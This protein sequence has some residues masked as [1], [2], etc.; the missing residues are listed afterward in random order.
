EEINRIVTDALAT[1]WFASEPDAVENLT[2]EGHSRERIHLVGNVMIDALRQFLPVAQQ[3]KIGHE[4]GLVEGDRIRPFA[5]LTLHRPANV[6]SPETLSK[7][8]PAVEAIADQIPIIFPV[9]PRT[10]QKLAAFTN[11]NSPFSQVRYVPPLR[12]LDF[13]FLLSQARL[14]LS[15]FGGIQ[16]G[17][18]APDIPCLTLR[19]NTE[20][21]ITVTEGTNQLVGNDPA[22]IIAAARGVLAGKHKSGRLPQFWDGRAAERIVQ[23]LLR[24]IRHANGRL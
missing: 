21:P 23:I 11:T 17:K 1:Y 5:L 10:Q 15:D 12:Y 3:S 24:E 19:E 4:L 9:H 14:V 7:V 22:N 6:D 13:L 16:G 18:T 20:R 2:H 8:L